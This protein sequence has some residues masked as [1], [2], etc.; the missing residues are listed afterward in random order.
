MPGVPPAPTPPGLVSLPQ[1]ASGSLLASVPAARCCMGSAGRTR[2][3]TAFENADSQRGAAVSAMASTA[4]H[5]CATDTMVC[6]SHSPG[7]ALRRRPDPSQSAKRR[8]CAPSGASAA[9][10]V[11]SAARC[12]ALY[13]QRQCAT[14]GSAASAARAALSSSP[15]RCAATTSHRALGGRAASSPTRR[16]CPR[17]YRPLCRC[18]R[19]CP[20]R[21]Y[22]RCRRHSVC[23]LRRRQRSM[24]RHSCEGAAMGA[25]RSASRRD[26]ARTSATHS[27]GVCRPPASQPMTDAALGAAGAARC[28][29]LGCLRSADTPICS[30]GTLLAAAAPAAVAELAAQAFPE[31]ASQAAT[32]PTE[33]PAA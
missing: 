3:C 21:S 15:C 8:P 23:W 12:C 1:A 29:P 27:R 19:R 25:W 17:P 7:A 24:A 14:A 20:A 30:S 13:R 11:C 28:P 9:T 10:Q 5:A 31:S 4:L 32:S 16:S 6:M 22:A 26:S 2:C 18:G 33:L